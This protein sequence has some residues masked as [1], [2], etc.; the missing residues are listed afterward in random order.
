[1]LA[2]CRNPRAGCEHLR[3][4]G[5]CSDRPSLVE[6]NIPQRPAGVTLEIAQELLQQIVG[7]PRGVAA[8]ET[9]DVRIEVV[10]EAGDVSLVLQSSAGP[11]EA[12]I[13]FESSIQGQSGTQQINT[14]ALPALAV[15]RE[16]LELTLTVF[17][18]PKLYSDACD[19][20]AI[21]ALDAI[22]ADAYRMR[23]RA[24]VADLATC[25]GS[26]DM[27]IRH[28]NAWSVGRYC[29]GHQSASFSIR[30]WWGR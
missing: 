29:D 21:S 30:A 20:E 16:T 23:L 1:M 24:L 6:H 2:S 17:P 22:C 4:D 28:D 3:G 7:Q 11:I 10:G 13:D 19:V 18:V 27:S 15:R 26:P 8:Q 5:R 25:S 9:V 12:D 14:V